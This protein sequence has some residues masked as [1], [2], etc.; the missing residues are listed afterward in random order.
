M[1]DLLLGGGGTVEVQSPSVQVD[2][3]PPENIVRVAG[4]GPSWT[5]L[6]GRFVRFLDTNGDPI[7]D[8]IVT[9]TV[10]T[11]TGQIDNITFEEL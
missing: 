9:I 11:T 10:N 7:D 6:F 3:A 8:G 1:V 5:A 2:V 4:A